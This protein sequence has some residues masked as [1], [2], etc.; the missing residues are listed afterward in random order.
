ME[1]G[2]ESITKL[3]QDVHPLDK[4]AELDEIVAMPLGLD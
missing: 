4:A 2:E 1:F 3:T